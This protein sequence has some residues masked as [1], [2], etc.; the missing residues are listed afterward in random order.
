[1][2]FS[3]LAPRRCR[4]S[5]R[6][7]GW[8]LT[9]TAFCGAVHAGPSY[10]VV[11]TYDYAGVRSIDMRYWGVQLPGHAAVS[12]LET[13]SGY[14]VN[15][16]WH[17]KLHGSRNGTGSTAMELR[18]LNWQNEFLPTQGEWPV[19]VAVRGSPI[20]SVF[21]GYR[22]T[23]IELGPVLQ[24]DVGRTQLDANLFFEHKWPDD[25]SPAEPTQLEH[26]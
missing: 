24:T 18:T 12:W 13:G 5:A 20:R 17:S 15:S 3:F 25:D 22:G 10:Y 23:E 4:R 2:P 19:D 7:L 21:G 11:T 9:A 6:A 1:M 16:R 14:G 26:Q 8:L